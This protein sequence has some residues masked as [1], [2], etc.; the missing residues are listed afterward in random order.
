MAHLQA[1]EMGNTSRGFVHYC[2]YTM[3]ERHLHTGGGIAWTCT[4]L[5][6]MKYGLSGLAVVSTCMDIIGWELH[7]S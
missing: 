5:D 2:S 6:V 4:L 3:V 7:I 1:D